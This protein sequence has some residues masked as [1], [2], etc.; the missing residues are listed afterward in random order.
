VILEVQTDTGEVYKR[1]DSG[2]AEL[3]WVTN[4]RA[5]ED[6]WRAEST[7]RDD[8]LLAGSDDTRGRLT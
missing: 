5:L 2:L 8:N 6:Q 4:T 7:T 1:L 3:L